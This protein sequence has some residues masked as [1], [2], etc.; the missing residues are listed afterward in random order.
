[1]QNCEGENSMNYHAKLI[2]LKT[3]SMRRRIWHKVLNKLERA[4]VNL[5]IRI[6]KKVR[7]PLLARVLNSI[8]N[9]LSNAL[10]SKVLTMTKLVGFTL[11]RKLS[12][13]AQSWGHKTAEMWAQDSKF[14]RFLAIMNLNSA[15][16][17][18]W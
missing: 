9:K 6:V 3:R 14:A 7:S 10:Q 4:Q 12:K 17:Y 1:M 8:I 18:S 5:T 16:T 13:I 2:E 15:P 11:A